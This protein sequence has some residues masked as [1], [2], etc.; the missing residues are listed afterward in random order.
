MT[1]V[2]IYL[3][4]GRESKEQKVVAEN[5]TGSIAFL[6]SMEDGLR[7]QWA[8]F[9]EEN[10]AERPSGIQGNGKDDLRRGAES[11]F[12]GFLQRLKPS[13]WQSRLRHG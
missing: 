12:R 5:L 7:P 1:F 8:F 4:Y 2:E 6:L 10:A 9:P 11:S 3:Q 13:C